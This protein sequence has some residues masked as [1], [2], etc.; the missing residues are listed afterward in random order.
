[1]AGI[2]SRL[3]SVLKSWLLE[4]EY[5]QRLELAIGSNAQEARAQ[6]KLNY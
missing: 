1:M 3:Q 5:Y 6:L 4:Q 2:D